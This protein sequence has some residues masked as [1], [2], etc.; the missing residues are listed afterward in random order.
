MSKEDFRWPLRH[1]PKWVMILVLVLL[2][3]IILVG[4][5]VVSSFTEDKIQDIFEEYKDVINS[6]E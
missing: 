1:L 4:V 5:C 3:P 2:F 6:F